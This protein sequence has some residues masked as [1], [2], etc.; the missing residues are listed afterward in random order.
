MRRDLA[1]GHAVGLLELAFGIPGCAG[2]ARQQ[3]VHPEEALKAQ[4]RQTSAIPFDLQS[5]LGL[6]CLVHAVLPVTI[7]L[8]ASGELIDHGHATLDHVVLLAS[9][10]AVNRRQRLLD[11]FV[12]TARRAPRADVGWCEKRGDLVLARVGELAA[13]ALDLDLKIALL[14]KPRRQVCCTTIRIF[15]PA[16]A[17]S[18]GDDQRRDSTVDEHCVC[19]IHN[20]RMKPGHTHAWVARLVLPIRAADGPGRR[21][22][23]GH[24]ITDARQ[25]QVIAQ[26]V[27]DEFFLSRVDHCSAKRRCPRCILHAGHHRPDTHARCF[28][29]RLHPACITSSEIFIG[30]HH[31]HR[32]PAPGQERPCD[33][34][35]QRLAFAG[36]HLH[37]LP[38][39]DRQS[40]HELHAIRPLPEMSI[41]QFPHRSRCV[42]QLIGRVPP[43]AKA[44]TQS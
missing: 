5:F 28:V 23:F 20:H 2:H 8:K 25:T 24:R 22:A 40:P 7:R 32:R 37:D 11:E 29:Q 31:M 38:V 43:P 26:P 10:V 35:R 16:L 3:R 30:G 12:P 15:K 1:H 27:A 41:R 6:H 21:E 36:G 42:K 13:P 18:H 33:R 19:F 39:H 17:P 14:D 34:S 4:T 44:L 9:L